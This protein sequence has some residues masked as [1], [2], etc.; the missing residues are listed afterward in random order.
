MTLAPFAA[1]SLGRVESDLRTLWEKER[2]GGARLQTMSVVAL[3]ADEGSPVR[4]AAALETAANQ[5]GA[6]TVLARFAP[7][8]SPSIDVE[9]GLYGT[10]GRPVA[11]AVRLVAHGAARSY[12]PDVAARLCTGD[13]P[14]VAWWVGDLPDHDPLFESISTTLRADLAVVDSNDMDLRDLPVLA[15]LARRFSIAD[16]CFRRLRTFQELCARFFD[17]GGVDA[18]QIER[19]VVRFSPRLVAPE[20]AST[21]AALFAGWF[22]QA[23]G[24]PDS[25][26]TFESTP[27][28]G[29]P[30]GGIVHVEMH[31]PGISLKLERPDDDP[32]VVCWSGEHPTLHLPKQCLRIHLPDDGKLLGGA[33]ERPVADPLYVKS[34]TR[35]ARLAAPIALPAPPRA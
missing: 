31:G 14:V 22:V 33:L 7:A 20:P 8:E 3:C 5:H 9:V 4:A 1:S 21:Q 12:L 32:L 25:A 16:L 34:L 35:A 17:E 24:L 29:M 23:L 13:L 6:R 15:G 2:P 28:E 26:V 11:E 27:R 18:R 10:P 30:A 19:L